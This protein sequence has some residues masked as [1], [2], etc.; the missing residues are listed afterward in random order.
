MELA[1]SRTNSNKSLSPPG[2]T[3]GNPE[4]P[5]SNDASFALV[6][7]CVI[8]VC[9]AVTFQCLATSERCQ[10]KDRAPANLFGEEKVSG[11]LPMRTERVDGRGGKTTCTKLRED[12]ELCVFADGAIGHCDV[13]NVPQPCPDRP[14]G[15]RY[16]PSGGSNLTGPGIRAGRSAK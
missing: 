3:G 5:V 4:T 9:Q 15:D 14:E 12:V 8:S 11:T 1:S 16:E 7:G 13:K 10:R 6:V 2:P